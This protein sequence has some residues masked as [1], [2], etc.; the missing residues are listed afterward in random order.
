MLTEQCCHIDFPVRTIRKVA[1]N[2]VARAISLSRH[3]SE[4][5]LRIDGVAKP[6]TSTLLF[7]SIF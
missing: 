1:T 7:S 2:Q 3:Q 6:T 4:L 5:P